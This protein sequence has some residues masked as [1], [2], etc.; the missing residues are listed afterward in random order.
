MGHTEL[1]DGTV[2]VRAGRDDSYVGGVL[3]GGD[4]T[5]SEDDLLPGL[6]DVDDVDEV[7]AGLVDVRGHLLLRDLGADVALR[8]EELAGLHI[9]T[10]PRP[11]CQYAVSFSLP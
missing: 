4:D 8:S 10:S 3:D 9:I 7:G 6:G 11:A 2:S 1:E 5:R